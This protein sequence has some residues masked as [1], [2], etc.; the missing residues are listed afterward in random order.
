MT[1]R[2]QKSQILEAVVAV[3]PV[4]MVQMQPERFAAPLL[5]AALGTL[6][7][8][9]HLKEA[10]SDCARLVCRIFDEDVFIRQALLFGAPPQDWIRCG[11]SPT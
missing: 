4:A 1:V 6:I 3:D 11:G 5:D 7:F 9:T 8:P 2:T 10:T